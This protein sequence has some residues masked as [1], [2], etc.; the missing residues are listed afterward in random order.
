M[1]EEE[2]DASAIADEIV[3]HHYD[4]MLDELKKRTGLSTDE[5]KKSLKY[6]SIKGLLR[7]V[8]F[9]M[10]KAEIERQG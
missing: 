4:N 7:E 2:L 5:L 10:V 9:V 6:K 1:D 3:N 8:M